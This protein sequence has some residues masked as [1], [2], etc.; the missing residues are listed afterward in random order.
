MTSSENNC[1]RAAKWISS[2]RVNEKACSL[3]P[4]TYQK[5][6]HLD[7]LPAQ[8]KLTVTALGIYEA[9]LNGKKVGEDFF[10]PGYTNYKSHIQV[11]EYDVLPLLK[12][13]ENVLEVTVANGWYLGRIGNQF[14]V[15][16]NCRALLAGLTFDGAVIP[17][18]ES[19]RVTL[20]G[21]VRFADFYDGETIDLRK[22]ERQYFPVQLYAGKTPKL[23]PHFGTFVRA[24]EALVPVGS[25]QGARGTIYDFGQNF[26]GVVRL[27][28]RAKEG[29]CITVR[30]AEILMDG[31]LFN[32]NY[33]TAKAALTLIAREGENEFF[34][35]FTYMGF[36]YAEISGDKPIEVLS[37]EGVVYSSE[38]RHIGSFACSDERLNRLQSCLVWNLKSNFVEIP[39]DCP[40]RDERLGWTGE[41]CTFSRTACFNYD[42]STFMNKWLFDLYS[43]QVDGAVPSAAPSTGMYDPSPQKPIPLMMWGDSAVVVPWM[44][45][46]AYGDR[47]KLN[48]H[49]P[50]M[51]A[52][53]LSEKRE[54]ERHGKGLKQYLW[55]KNK[56]Q[57]GDW[58][59]FGKTWYTWN[60]RGKHLATLWYYNSVNLV[61]EAARTL[62][63]S[64][65][66]KAFSE[67]AANIQRAFLKA[68]LRSDG[69]FRHAHFMSMY[70]DAL[71]F[72][73]LPER[74]RALAAKQ[75]AELVVKNDYRV[76]TGFPGTPYLLF[77]LADNGYPELAFKVLLNERCPGWLHMVKHGATTLW[78]RWDAIEEDGSFFHGGAGM[79]SFNHYAYGTV[80]DFF[81]RR[82]L[83]LETIEAGY[84]TFLVRPVC[85]PLTEAKGELQTAFGTICVAWKKE[86][87]KF[88]LSVTVP[89]SCAA[90]IVMP[91]G[92]E[93]PVSSGDYT[94]EEEL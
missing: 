43:H 44:L 35:T 74:E 62:G 16:G 61:K 40:Q 87:G 93:H 60:R 85:G 81:Y 66:E 51:K 45:Y 30:H 47:A 11:Q 25:R 28:V 65:D 52:Y 91:S 3:P 67:L 83:G 39:T 33:R 58:A 41:T 50:H 38:M 64:E 48:E 88:R 5:T 57:F 22:K 92:T 13:G 4:E 26:A 75:L 24:Q 89:A 21:P 19:W 34:P 20:D 37:V 70:V 2:G 14:N 9:Y 12:A 42:I 84:R 6:F 7:G 8:A 59:C 56:Y 1:M 72:G 77:A 15:Y 71:Y 29:T 10:T 78:E 90:T 76:M 36:R 49:Y 53:A 68:Y 17:T 54:A 82:I 46:L 73:I 69:S 94:F 86:G 18:D 79:V 63:Y 27:K 23:I 31:K 55:D 32:E 80:G